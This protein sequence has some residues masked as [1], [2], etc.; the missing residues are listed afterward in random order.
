MILSYGSKKPYSDIDIFIVSNNP[1]RNYFN[2]WLDIYELNVKD[3]EYLKNN[4]DISITDP[5]STGTQIYGTTL[6]KHQNNILNQPITSEAINHN[7]LRSIQQKEALNKTTDARLIKIAT[8]YAKTY[9]LNAKELAQGNKILM[10]TEIMNKY[11][12]KR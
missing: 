3:F 5:I 8:G 1:S 12:F 4:L 7:I 2:G 11:D 10:L 9:E 6:E